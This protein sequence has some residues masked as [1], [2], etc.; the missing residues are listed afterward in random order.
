MSDCPCRVDLS[1]WD[2]KLAEAARLATEARVLREARGRGCPESRAL[3]GR[4]DRLLRPLA[5]FARNWSDDEI[6][7]LLARMP[8]CAAAAGLR[9]WVAARE[10]GLRL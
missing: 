7:A 8:E 5:R 2:G 9:R 10:P 3:N 4:A 1:P 6:R